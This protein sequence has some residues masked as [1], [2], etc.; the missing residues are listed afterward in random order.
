MI[1]MDPIL[2]V[3]CT[4]SLTWIFRGHFKSDSGIPSCVNKEAHCC[5]VTQVIFYSDLFCWNE[6]LTLK[7]QQ[8][9]YKQIIPSPPASP[10]LPASP[11][12]P[13]LCI[14]SYRLHVRRYWSSTH[15][16]RW[17]S[18]RRYRLNRK[19]RWRRRALGKGG[20]VGEPRKAPNHRAKKKN[21]NVALVELR[22]CNRCWTCSFLGDG[23]LA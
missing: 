14:G 15:S 20:L 21:T 6:N 2:W 12:P 16:T 4:T 13:F 18:T 17:R 5:Q 19:R 9:I 7:M 11:A 3:N 22:T 10:P 1:Y 8:K 23:W